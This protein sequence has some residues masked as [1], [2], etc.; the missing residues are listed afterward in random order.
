LWSVLTDYIL[1]VLQVHRHPLVRKTHH[2]GKTWRIWSAVAKI[3]LDCRE[4][5]AAQHS[6]TILVCPLF[7]LFRI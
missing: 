2:D 7:V 5:K 4:T 3:Q 1:V 6:T